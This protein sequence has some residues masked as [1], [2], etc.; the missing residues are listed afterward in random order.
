MHYL[1]MLLGSLLSMLGINEPP[2]QTSV[3]RISGEQALLSRTT[4][5]S[6]VAKFQCLQSESGSCVYQLYREQC[7]AGQGAQVCNREPLMDFVVLVGRTRQ[8]NN[9]PEG[10]GQQVLIRK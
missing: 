10:F 8:M 4:V 9:L 6:G 7:G 1:T 5:R 3:T 2:G